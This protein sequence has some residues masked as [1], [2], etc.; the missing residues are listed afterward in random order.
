[1]IIADDNSR[2][3]WPGFAKGG[4]STTSQDPHLLARGQRDRAII[5][6][7]AA[8]LLPLPP[9]A[10]AAVDQLITDGL[11]RSPRAITRRA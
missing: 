1:M 2:A 5:M 8:L 9:A 10:A 11:P 6:L 3:S 4:R 7:A